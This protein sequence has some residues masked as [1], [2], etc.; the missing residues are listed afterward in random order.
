VF[1]ELPH[2]VLDLPREKPLPRIKE[3]TKWEEFARMPIY[4]FVLLS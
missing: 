4:L 2:S 1:A 3:K